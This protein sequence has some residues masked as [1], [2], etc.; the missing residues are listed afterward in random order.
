MNLSAK[1]VFAS[2]F[3][4]RPLAPNR[5]E[6]S[7]SWHTFFITHCPS[8]PGLKAHP[9]VCGR[10]IECR[11]GKVI[12][13]EVDAELNFPKENLPLGLLDRPSIFDAL[14]EQLGLKLQPQKGPVKYYVIDHLEKPSGN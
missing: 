10:A 11:H 13:T 6:P 5:W 7:L 14:K 8:T 1:L 12:E 9:V 3:R 4:S 2:W